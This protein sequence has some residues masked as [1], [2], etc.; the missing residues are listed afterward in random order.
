MSC[1]RNIKNNAIRVS[2]IGD[3]DR[4][5]TGSRNSNFWGSTIDVMTACEKGVALS[6][7]D[8]NIRDSRGVAKAL[9]GDFE[10]AIDDFEAF[11]VYTSSGE[12]RA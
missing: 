6:P 2:F 5:M 4:G 3:I 9:T 10:G 12:A 8:G 1:F 7:K 11:V